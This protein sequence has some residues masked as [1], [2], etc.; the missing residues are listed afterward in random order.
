[1]VMGACL[2]QIPILC[3][4]PTLMA[5]ATMVVATFASSITSQKTRYCFNLSLRVLL[6]T[7]CVTR[8]YQNAIRLII[9]EQDA[10]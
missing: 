1:M 6:I 7:Q 10:H 4:S 5:T 9:T 8:S 3:V 2:G